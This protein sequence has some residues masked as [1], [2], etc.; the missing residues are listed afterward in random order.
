MFNSMR[1]RLRSIALL[2]VAAA[3]VVGGVAAAQSGSPGDS[4]GNG[5][6]AKTAGKLPPGPPMMGLAMPGLTY[7]ELH[8]QNKDG[9]AETIRVDQGKV[10]S[11][12]GDS[13]TLTANDDSEVTVA[14]DADTEVLGKP[15]EETS[16]GDLETGLQVSVSAPQGEAAQA[17]MVMPKK[18]DVVAGFHGAPGGPLPPPPGA[19]APRRSE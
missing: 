13:I 8:V 1:M 3:L 10:K 4:G 6:S 15:G 2:G 17:I 14:V 5:Q 12:D 11:V 19:P 18:G 7:A 9:E 16:L